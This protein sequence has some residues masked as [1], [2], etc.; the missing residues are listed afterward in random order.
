MAQLAQDSGL[1]TIRVTQILLV[2][3]SASSLPSPSCSVHVRKQKL[4]EL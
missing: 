1:I 4:H 2:A 3:L